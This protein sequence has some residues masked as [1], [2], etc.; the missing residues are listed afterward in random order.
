[1]LQAIIMAVAGDGLL[2]LMD[3]LIKSMTPRY[4]T[5]QIAFLRF[6][7][8]LVWASLVL[9]ILRPGW[10]SRETVFYNTTRSVLVVMTATSFFYALG[11]L[12]LADAVALSFLSPVFIALFGVIFLKERIDT[13]I[14]LALVAGFCG[15]MLIAG[16]RIGSGDYGDG[17]IFGTA[18]CVLSAVT[19]ALNLVLL[20]A[21]AQRDALSIIVWFQNA[22]PALVLAP[23]AALV[24]TPL[25]SGDLG[26]L[27][28]IGLLG[29]SGHFLL[30]LAFAR[31][32]AARL[33]PI[34]YV[35]LAWGVVFGYLFFADLPGLATIAGA[36]LIILGTIATHRRKI[37][38]PRAR[39][40][41][42]PV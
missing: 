41:K 34:H 22:G 15:M 35:T 26:L 33:A 42:R 7:S 29:V 39:S 31:A 6:S 12:P 13:R 9:A 11:E 4:P 14:I 24:W 23:A 2:S 30:A 3:A 28:L 40:E 37:E 16:G 20:R 19:Y 21:R 36:G 32:E 25:F 18:A 27:A 38:T 8:G 5:F 17:A 1:M 10:P